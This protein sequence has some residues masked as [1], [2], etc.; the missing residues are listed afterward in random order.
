ML[1]ELDRD[2][3]LDLV[4]PE[5][6]ASRKAGGGGGSTPPASPPP[7]SAA[8]V[9]GRGRGGGGGGTS[10]LGGGGTSV[11]GGGGA[12]AAGGGGS[13]IASSAED[14][15]LLRLAMAASSPPAAAPGAAG[16]GTIGGASAAIWASSSAAVPPASA[17]ADGG[18]AT[19]A[20]AGIDTGADTSA[21]GGAISVSAMP[22]LDAAFTVESF[23]FFF[24][25]FFFFFLSFLLVD[26]DRLLVDG[27]VLA[28]MELSGGG[29]WEGAGGATRLPELSR[30]PSFPSLPP[31]S[32]SSRR[33]AGSENCSN[34]RSSICCWS[35][36]ELPPPRDRKGPISRA[37][38]P[39]RFRRSSLLSPPSM[40]LRISTH[41]TA[42][43]SPGASKRTRLTAILEASM[44][45]SSKQVPVEDHD[46]AT[47]VRSRISCLSTSFTA[48]TSDTRISS[49]THSCL[50]LT[51]PRP[52][53][54]PGIPLQRRSLQ[55]GVADGVDDDDADEDDDDDDD[56]DDDNDVDDKDEGGERGRALLWSWT[57]TSSTHSFVHST[58]VLSVVFPVV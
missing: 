20:G 34:T 55:V 50:S 47:E 6:D 22:L 17:S 30:G 57:T 19:T 18:G 46:T 37:K 29:G 13:A 1:F 15:P 26:D 16:G 58:G 5:R 7:L 36:C 45:L 8:T 31:P 21:G 25:F 52:S 38:S 48:S 2:D 28:E 23:R 11:P 43:S 56:D 32:A 24:F 3:D 4:L 27:L 10:A 53:P 44:T 9:P 51:P 40:A 49:Q 41:R 39:T 12:T 54:S 14:A 33:H 35:S 42:S